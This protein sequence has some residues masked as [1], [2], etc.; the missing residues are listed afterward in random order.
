M[1]AALGIILELRYMWST[2]WERE[3][4]VTS[5]VDATTAHPPCIFHLQTERSI[6]NVS[7][8]SIR[9]YS[10][11]QRRCSLA[12]IHYQWRHVRRRKSSAHDAHH[13][14]GVLSMAHI[15]ARH[16]IPMGE[17]H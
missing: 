7:Y 16:T 10:Q 4:K 13:I 11:H 8:T 5:D 14:T 6:I 17:A 12:Y 3:V 15:D 9:A 1:A 2:C